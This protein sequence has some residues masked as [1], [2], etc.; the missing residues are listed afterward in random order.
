MSD[1]IPPND[2]EAERA[3]IGCVVMFGDDA[4][5]R[6]HGIHPGDFFD[7]SCR[8]AWAAIVDLD[9]RSA[10]INPIAL[11]DELKARGMA[12]RFAPSALQWLT[13][14]ASKAPVLAVLSHH[15]G[16]IR[17]K[18]TLR[19]LIALCTEVSAMCYGNQPVDDVMAVARDGI[20]DLEVYDDSDGPAKIGDLLSGALDV[21]EERTRKGEDPQAVKTGICTLDRILGGAKPQQ[22]ILIAGRP[23]DGKTSLAD[24]ISAFQ[25]TRL[26]APCL[27]FSE[28]MGAQEVVE[29]ILGLQAKVEVSRI[30]NGK[31][32]YSEWKKIT[33][34]AGELQS[35]PLFL[36]D[37]PLTISQIVGQAR[38]WHAKEVR[39]KGAKRCS[40]VIDYAQIVS[41]DASFDTKTQEQEISI[42][43]GQSKRL[44]KT[45]KCPVYLICQLNRKVT[46]RGGPPILADLRGSGALEQDADVV[47]FVY[48]DIPMEDQEKRNQSGP[49]QIIIGKHRGGPTGIASVNW[50]KEWMQFVAAA[51]AEE[52]GSRPNW[53]DEGDE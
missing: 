28:E 4:M 23:G 20:A 19:S 41:V 24:N 25:T 31:I 6:S 37:R 26:Q 27:F 18:A 5:A 29:R 10:N 33:T 52:D 3:V 34:A 13:E 12:G 30:G 45:L 7:P 15:I 46:E 22:M 42:V 44:A 51:D 35:V 40:I 43:S 21:I 53:Q 2:V 8:E 9:K 11:A 39:G 38:R 14:S 17:A 1:L 50:V 32:D 47:L 49:A 16:I 48:R 36:D